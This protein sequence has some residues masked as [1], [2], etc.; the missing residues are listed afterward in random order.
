MAK[1][2]IIVISVTG[3]VICAIGWITRYISCCALVYYMQKKWVQTSE[4]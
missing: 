4:R 1:E 3:C 2:I